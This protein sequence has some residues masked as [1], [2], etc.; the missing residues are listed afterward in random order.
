MELAV[1]TSPAQLFT[2][3][4]GHDLLASWG[5]EYRERIDDTSVIGSR[6]SKAPEDGELVNQN[7][8]IVGWSGEIRNSEKI[9]SEYSTPDQGVSR[10]LI[11]LFRRDG[12]SAL[13]S[14]HTRGLL[15][16]YDGQTGRLLIGRDR[17]G[18]TPVT[19]YRGEKIFA[20]ATCPT[21]LRD[22]L[23]VS[24]SPN[25]K[26]LAT[27]L[28]RIPRTGREDCV[29]PFE[30]VLPGEV[31]TVDSEGLVD[32]HRYYSRPATEHHWESFEEESREL[33]GTLRATVEEQL[34][35]EVIHMMSGGIDSTTLMSLHSEISNATKPIRTASL[36]ASNASVQDE[37]DLISEMLD[38]Y[39]VQSFICDLSDGVP[40]TD[41]R[42]LEDSG[43]WG[44]QWHPGT[45]YELHFV[46]SISDFYDGNRIVAGS[47][48]DFLFAGTLNSSIQSYLAHGQLTD[49]FRQVAANSD[50][51][52]ASAWGL[53][54]MLS[55]IAPNHLKSGF[56]RV[57]PVQEESREPWL[58]PCRWTRVG[59]EQPKTVGFGDFGD[60]GVPYELSWPWEHTVRERRR[61]ARLAGIKYIL[62][63]FEATLV[64]RYSRLPES[65]KFR[66][67]YRKAILRAAANDLLPEKVLHASKRLWIGGIIELSMFNMRFAIRELFR[68]SR[69]AALGLIDV[70]SFLEAFSA[71]NDQVRRG[72][73]NI[74]TAPLWCTISAEIWLKSMFE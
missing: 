55:A 19:L 63:Y 8:A 24:E 3:E 61:K 66:N 31:V 18:F 50:W 10:G 15:V 58:N 51:L 7:G 30:R 72:R 44:P 57:F 28:M 36:T 17:F 62:P 20:A 40:V 52:S 45:P 21:A 59:L 22:S 53:R 1:F 27:Y 74:G 38:A 25:R 26:R 43:A 54:R 34:D 67:G 13:E 46:R 14:I 69:L 41:E 6:Y 56:R 16:F 65:F 68:E 73:R 64:E 12:I 9:V 42:L 39:E 70:D 48:A 11:E 5:A 33:R 29:L 23:T 32:F 71:F 47:G 37:S 35:D 49:A 4:G 2:S 60:R